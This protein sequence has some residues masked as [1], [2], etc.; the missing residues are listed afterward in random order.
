MESAQA[1]LKTLSPP[2]KIS[3]ARRWLFIDRHR[4]R[5]HPRED[6]RNASRQTDT[7]KY[8]FFCVNVWHKM[9]FKEGSN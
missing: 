1:H 6:A 2:K 5:S 3:Y 4:L 7:K 8:I 9:K